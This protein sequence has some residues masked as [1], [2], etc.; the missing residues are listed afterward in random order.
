MAFKDGCHFV[1]LDSYPAYFDLIV[2]TAEYGERAVRSI[3]PLIPRM[4]DNVV[5]VIPETI[6][7]EAP[8]LLLGI[9]DITKRAE[10]RA[11]YDLSDLAGAAQ[12]SV[13]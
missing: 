9:V 10:W 4:V 11:Q 7:H 5:R 13:F 8:L 3:T 12:L 2:E 6:P 1:G